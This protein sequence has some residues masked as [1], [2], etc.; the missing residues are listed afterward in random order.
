VGFDDPASLRVRSAKPIDRTRGRKRPEYAEAMP[1]ACTH[2]DQ[3]HQVD[4][5]T[6]DGCEECLR[7]GSRWVHLRLCL[8]CGHVGCCD[9]SPNRHASA[10]AAQTGHPIVQSFEPG[11]DWRWCYVDETYV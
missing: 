7:D 8:T 1:P 3:I 9:S 6:P 10:H 4:A 2:T 5:N 11:E